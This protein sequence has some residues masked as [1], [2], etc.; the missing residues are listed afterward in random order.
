MTDNLN[1]PEL[2]SEPLTCG[3]GAEAVYFNAYRK[4]CEYCL[5]EAAYKFEM[6]AHEFIKY[7]NLE[8]L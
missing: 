3:C 6:T 5:F 8:E 7:E 2:I 4:Y 1:P